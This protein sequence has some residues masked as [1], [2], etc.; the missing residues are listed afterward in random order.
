MEV[1]AT[2]LN[3]K[4]F[5]VKTIHFKGISCTD[6]TINYIKKGKNIQELIV[7]YDIL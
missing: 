5:L 2:I 7:T 3:F 6:I 4:V 1:S